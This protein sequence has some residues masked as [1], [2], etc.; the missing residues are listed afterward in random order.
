MPVPKIVYENTAPEGKYLSNFFMED[1]AFWSE[2]NDLKLDTAD[3]SHFGTLEKNYWLL[4]GN[5]EVIP[6]DYQAYK[7]GLVTDSISDAKGFFI[8]PP[9]LIINLDAPISSPSIT[10]DFD[11]YRNRWCSELEIAYYLNDTLIQ[12]NTF[13]PNASRYCCEGAVDRYNKVVVTFKQT[14]TPNSRV[15]VNA[16]YY[17]NITTFEQSQISALSV[18]EEINPISSEIPVNTMEFELKEYRDVNFLFRKLQPLR[19]YYGEKLIGLYFINSSNRTGVA[20]YAIECIDALG[21]IDNYT[22]MG[23]LYTSK[24]AEQ[25]IDE[26][27]GPTYRSYILDEDLKSIPVTGYIG[28]CTCREALMQVAFA[29]GAV[30][31]TSRSNHINITTIDKFDTSKVYTESDAHIGG[32]SNINS[33]ITSVSITSHSYSL[34]TSETSQVF[35][36][37]LLPG[38]YSIQNSSPYTNY[39]IEGGTI[40]DSDVNYVNFSVDKEGEVIISG[41]GYEDAQ[42]VHTL[43]NSEVSVFSVDNTKSVTDCTL[44]NKNNVEEILSRVYNYCMKTDEITN[45]IILDET[46]VGDTITIPTVYNETARGVVISNT[47]SFG[48]KLRGEVKILAD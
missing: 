2:L 5:Y 29:I 47:M 9:Q 24:P 36:S 48:N 4:D 39:T 31:D 22:F 15:R 10:F 1:I 33:V 35:K 20:D 16:L 41:N 32:N 23:G 30:I 26:I 12:N 7:Y 21:A 25:L 3:I 13:Y 27:L 43:T 28:I 44:V 46:K 34:K 8:T 11:I 38:S 6:Y 45:V 40:T 18:L 14:N 19:L 37:T 17:G 42:N